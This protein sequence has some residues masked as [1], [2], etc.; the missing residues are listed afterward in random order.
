M[1]NYSLP[2]IVIIKCNRRKTETMYQNH[3]NRSVFLSECFTWF[4]RDSFFLFHC[5]VCMHRTISPSAYKNKIISCISVIMVCFFMSSNCWIH[6]DFVC[7]W[8]RVGA[9]V[10]EMPRMNSYFYWFLF[11][12]SFAYV[13]NWLHVQLSLITLAHDI[14]HSELAIRISWT[15]SA[16]RV[17]DMR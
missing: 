8:R 4:N 14:S 11:V 17:F 1:E 6:L 15:S 13:P 16:Y 5:A 10:A 12:I 2:L 7:K 9:F 3:K